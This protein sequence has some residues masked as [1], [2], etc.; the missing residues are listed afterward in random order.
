VEGSSFFVGHGHAPMVVGTRRRP[1]APG[2]VRPEPVE[3]GPPGAPTALLRCRMVD[4]RG[5][6]RFQRVF[7]RLFVRLFRLRKGRL[8]FRGA[9]SL[10]LH[11]RGRRSGAARATP[12]LYLDLGDGRVAVVASNGGD[13]RTP[14]WVHNLLASPDVEADVGR[15][16]RPYRAAVAGPEARAELWPRAVAI[17]PGFGEYQAKT[18]REIPM[19][20]L[21]PRPG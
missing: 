14:A 21:T 20:V 11:T 16:R 15:A 9:P 8:A 10:V 2:E 17:Y 4:R 19:I 5:A 1:G 12:L 3:P 6:A 18:S 7:N 13:D